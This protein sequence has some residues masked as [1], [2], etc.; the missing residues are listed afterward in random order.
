MIMFSV[1]GPNVQRRSDGVHTAG[2]TAEIEIVLTDNG[3]TWF[4]FFSLQ[5]DGAAVACGDGETT[6]TVHP[7][8]V[9]TGPTLASGVQKYQSPL[10]HI[11]QRWVVDLD[12][13]EVWIECHSHNCAVV[14]SIRIPLSIDTQLLYLFVC[15]CVCLSTS[16]PHNHTSSSHPTNIAYTPKIHTIFA[17]THSSVVNPDVVLCPFE[18]QGR[19]DDQECAYQHLSARGE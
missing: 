3:R 10:D 17:H 9:D 2:T 16:Y 13:L 5:D 15:A 14:V 11:T 12:G 1:R 8:A 18:M 4:L 19:C 6:T 7:T